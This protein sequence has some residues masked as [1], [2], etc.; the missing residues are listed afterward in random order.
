LPAPV[1]SVVYSVASVVF[2]GPVGLAPACA[3][4]AQAA[5]SYYHG[6]SWQDAVK[7]GVIAA[8]SAYL[9]QQAGTVGDADSYARYAAHAGAGCVS[10]VANGGQCGHGAASA[11]IGKGITNATGDWGVIGSGVAAITAG[12]ISSV[13]GGGTFANGARTAAYGYLFNQ[14]L[15]GRLQNAGKSEVV[16]VINNNGVF[17][18]HAGMF[19][20][21]ELID[22]AG[23]YELD[24]S[25]VPAWK[26]P[27]LSDYVK[28]QMGDGDNIRIYRFS[29]TQSIIDSMITRDIQSGNTLPLFC[30]TAVQNTI[31][32][33]GPFT[34]IQSTTWVSPSGLAT[35][36]N[37][38]GG[39]VCLRPDGKSC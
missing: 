15:S 17:G 6:A 32:G 11:V 30:A 1:A 13:I 7:S 38:V 4:A 25:I 16:V 9:F 34:N 39:G 20:G 23:N 3:G 28:Y 24:R 31:A 8:A 19:V 26:G 5:I 29:V 18:S 10:S 35:R 36:L 21:G 37:G 12:G 14:L 2:C 27:S 33:L 22:P